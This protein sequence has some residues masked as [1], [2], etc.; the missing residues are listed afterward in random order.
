MNKIVPLLNYVRSLR[1]AC[2]HFLELPKIVPAAELE[3]LIREIAIISNNALY[4]AIEHYREFC[5][6]PEIREQLDKWVESKESN[7]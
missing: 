1:L 3:G 6:L 4:E 7:D 2:R 5:E